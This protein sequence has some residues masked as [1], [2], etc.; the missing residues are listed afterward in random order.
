MNQAAKK[1]VPEH[2]HKKLTDWSREAENREV[3]EFEETDN[4]R[5]HLGTLLRIAQGVERLVELQTGSISSK[6]V[7]APPD[8]GPE[9]KPHE[10][11]A[12]GYAGGSHG[13]TTNKRARTGN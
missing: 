4:Y 1:P 2:D 5:V 9:R 6:V 12:I 7:V 13:R 3:Y 8:P 10:A 11:D